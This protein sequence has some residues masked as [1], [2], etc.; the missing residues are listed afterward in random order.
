MQLPNNHPLREAFAKKK[1]PLLQLGCVG[2]Y[3]AVIGVFEVLEYTPFNEKGTCGLKFQ[4]KYTPTTLLDVG[5][6]FALFQVVTP[7]IEDSPDVWVKHTPTGGPDKSPWSNWSGN[8]YVDSCQN[9]NPIFGVNQKSGGKVNDLC[10]CEGNGYAGSDGRIGEVT[11]IGITPAF[12]SDQPQRSFIGKKMMHLFETVA[13]CI[14]GKQKGMCLGVLTWGYGVSPGG[15]VIPF[16]PKSHKEFSTTFELA[17][18]DTN[19]KGIKV[20][21]IPKHYLPLKWDEDEK[22]VMGKNENNENK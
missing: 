3:G 7:L 4:L 16:P 5:C 15:V 14:E 10:N 19:W 11:V 12:M 21:G 18:S 9:K 1:L 22:G 6:K 8:S 2:Q 13:L 17:F 20:P